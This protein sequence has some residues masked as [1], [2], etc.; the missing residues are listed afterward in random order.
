VCVAAAPDGWSGPAAVVADTPDVPEPGCPAPF[1]VAQTVAFD[2]LVAPPADCTCDCGSPATPICEA[3]I[4][5]DNS[6]GCGSPTDSWTLTGS[7]QTDV[8]A[9]GNQYWRATAGPLTGT[10]TPQSSEELVDPEFGQRQTLCA[11]EQ[12]SG[13]CSGADVCAPIPIA[14]FT[15]D[16]L[17]IWAAGDLEC[18]ADLGYD[19]RRLLFREFTDTRRCSECDCSLEGE[20]TGNVYLFGAEGCFDSDFLAGTLTINGACLQVISAVSEADRNLWD[21]DASCVEVGGAPE[22]AAVGADPVTLCCRE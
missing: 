7:C 2:E 10:C 14:P 13:A 19:A 17:C 6:A 21:I 16:E 8:D 12:A 4:V 5:V 15:A 22:G 11:A 9:P 20:C 3:E 1:P 18:P